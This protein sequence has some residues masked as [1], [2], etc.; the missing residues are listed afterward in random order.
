MENDNQTTRCEECQRKETQRIKR[1]WKRKYDR[2]KKVE[3]TNQ[4]KFYKKHSVHAG[5]GLFYFSLTYENRIIKLP[6][7]KN[8]IKNGD[9]IM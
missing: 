9:A 1:E 3:R 7:A 2:A 5:F 4:I 6:D 8:A